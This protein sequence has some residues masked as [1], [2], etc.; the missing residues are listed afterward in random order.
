MDIYR[1]KGGEGWSLEVAT[2]DGTSI[3]WD[4]LF[5][6]DQAAFEETLATIRKEDPEAFFKRHPI[7]ALAERYRPL[8]AACHH[9]LAILH[10]PPN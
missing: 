8:A 10:C 2:G 9:L 3:V 1:Q 4:D 6:D 7:Y 5:D